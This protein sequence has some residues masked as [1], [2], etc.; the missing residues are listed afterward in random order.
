M[1]L[2]KIS[3]DFEPFIKSINVHFAI[4]GFLVDS[5]VIDRIM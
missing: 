1:Y 4:F 2:A 3:I 5:N